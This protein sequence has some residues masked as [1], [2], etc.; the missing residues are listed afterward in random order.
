MPE[1]QTVWKSNNQ[2]VKLK[3]KHSSRPVGGEEM[4]SQGGEDSRQ[5]TGWRTGVGKAAE[6]EVPH[7]CADTPEG[8]TGE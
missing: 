8:T 3:K 7:L 6:R 4:G 2:E 1:N 5:G